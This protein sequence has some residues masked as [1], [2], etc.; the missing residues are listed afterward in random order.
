M[1]AYWKEDASFSDAMGADYRDVGIGMARLDGVPLYTFLFAWPEREFFL[2]LTA[3]LAD[4]AAVRD[5]MLAAVNAARRE[6]GL[7]PLALDAELN[8]AAQKH[9]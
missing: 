1:L 7:E 6:A 4:L 5:Q 9:A 2:R 3:P 8:A